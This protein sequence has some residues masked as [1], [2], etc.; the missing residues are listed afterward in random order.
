MVC[1]AGTWP[2]KWLPFSGVTLPLETSC[3]VPIPRKTMCTCVGCRC[4]WCTATTH[5]CVTRYAFGVLLG[6][7]ATGENASDGDR[8]QFQPPYSQ[9]DVSEYSNIPALG[10][11]Y[12][13]CVASNPAERPTI[14]AV[15]NALRDISLQLEVCSLKFMCGYVRSL[16]LTCV[17][18]LLRW[19]SFSRAR[20]STTQLRP[21]PVTTTLPLPSTCVLPL[22]K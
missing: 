18:G 7:I 13:R 1:V 15:A 12:A 21:T 17:G 10:V 19:T 16:R 22:G 20:R 3:N 11:L 5:S 6:C 4:M 9:R 8:A 2:Q 14:Q